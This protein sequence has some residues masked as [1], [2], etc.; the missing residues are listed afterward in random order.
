MIASAYRYSK[1]V[2]DILLS[3]SSVSITGLIISR[4][5]G[6]SIVASSSGV[7]QGGNSS[8]WDGFFGLM[9]ELF[10]LLVHSYI[11][12]SVSWIPTVT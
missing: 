6:Q 8:A 9:V 10:L 11:C 7:V 1:C 3:F 12:S 5:E 2:L 4:I